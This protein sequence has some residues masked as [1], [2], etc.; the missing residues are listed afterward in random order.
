MCFL[1]KA[2]LE[3]RATVPYG[4]SQR[5]IR[6]RGFS[7]KKSRFAIRR[8]EITDRELDP[9]RDPRTGHAAPAKV[10]A[11]IALRLQLSLPP[12]RA[13]LTTISADNYADSGAS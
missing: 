7:V 6:S 9:T 1:R 8:A 13:S 10:L 12:Q 2:Y 5:L 4:F 11:E 3:S